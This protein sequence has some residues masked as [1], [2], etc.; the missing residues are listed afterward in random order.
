VGI[1]LTAFF[2]ALP[3]NLREAGDLLGIIVLA[4]TGFFVYTIMRKRDTVGP[5]ASR[6]ISTWNG[7]SFVT[8]SIWR[9]V[10]GVQ[11]IG[12]SRYFYMAL[13]LSL[14]VLV[15]QALAFWLVMWSYGLRSSFWVG[16]VVFMIVHLGTALPN[17]PANLGTYQF[18]CVVGLALFGVEKTPATGFSLVVFVILT[19]PLWVLGFIALRY[20][21]STLYAI[22]D[23]INRWTAQ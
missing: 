16:F 10:S 7:S 22:R 23:E 4:A 14:L 18:F 1:G 5:P 15:L 19:I 8:S 3:A 6:E 17:A 21:G 11:R 12:R 20:S 2:V 9:L 13:G